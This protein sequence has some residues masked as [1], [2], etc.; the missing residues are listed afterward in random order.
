MDGPRSRAGLHLTLAARL[1]AQVALILAAH[2]RRALLEA[3]EGPARGASREVLVAA[4]RSAARA[5]ERLRQAD[6]GVDL[7][8]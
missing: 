8:G 4:E 5:Q 6:T 2:A 1:E 7:L 3:P